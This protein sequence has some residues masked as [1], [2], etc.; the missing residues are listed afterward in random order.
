MV[1]RKSF[2]HR[3]VFR[4]EGGKGGDLEDMVPFFHSLSLILSSLLSFYLILYFYSTLASRARSQASFAS[5]CTDISRLR[6]RRHWSSLSFH[7]VMW[8][9]LGDIR[10]RCSGGYFWGEIVLGA[11]IRGA[12]GSNCDPCRDSQI[13]RFANLT[14][15]P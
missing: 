11:S 7:S 1:C 8:R 9:T 5:F 2:T 13:S 3:G 14:V 6:S 12:Y 10:Y 15:R 4:E